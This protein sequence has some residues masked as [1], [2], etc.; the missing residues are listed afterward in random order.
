MGSSA[1]HFSLDLAWESFSP[2]PKS[3]SPFGLQKWVSSCS[4]PSTFTSCPSMFFH[5]ISIGSPWNWIPCLLTFFL[6]SFLKLYPS[7]FWQNKAYFSLFSM[8]VK[9]QMQHSFPDPFHP[10]L[11]LF[12]HSLSLLA[13]QLCCFLIYLYQKKQVCVF[14]KI[15]PY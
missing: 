7:H 4:T 3:Q 13:R 12:S 9:T 15:S 1:T 5:Q 10:F 6:F 2:E 11:A 14:S 8:L